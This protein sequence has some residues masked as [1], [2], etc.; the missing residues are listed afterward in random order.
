MSLSK[1]PERVR[2]LLH[3]PRSSFLCGACSI[4]RYRLI[5]EYE[6]NSLQRNFPPKCLPGLH[7]S[8]SAIN[9]FFL[10]KRTNQC[11][12]FTAILAQS[13]S[14]PHSGTSG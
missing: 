5:C 1:R 7:Q 6:R 10:E 3:M 13:I 8:F 11:T 12:A 9:F 2:T 4:R 14:M